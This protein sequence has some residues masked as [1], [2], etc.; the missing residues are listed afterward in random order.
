MLQCHFLDKIRIFSCNALFQL[1]NC[2]LNEKCPPPAP[3]FEHLFPNLV[4]LF[5]EGV[6]PSGGG[7]G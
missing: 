1:E 2:G 3:E 6:E 7:T 5:G 4:L